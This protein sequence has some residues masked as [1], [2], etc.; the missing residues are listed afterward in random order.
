MVE[1]QQNQVQI[2][3]EIQQALGKLNVRITDLMEQ[4]NTVIAVLVNE[5]AELRTKLDSLQ[6]NNTC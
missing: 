3:P 6:S 5:N 1:Q 4:I 2:S